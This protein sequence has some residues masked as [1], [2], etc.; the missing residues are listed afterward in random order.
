MCRN[1]KPLFNFS[2]EAT[3]EEVYQA[4]LQYVRKLSG[5]SNPSQLNEVAFYKA[6]DNVAKSTREL[7]L[8]LSTTSPKRDRDIETAKR[9]AKN[10]KRFATE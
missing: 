1:I 5:F 3:D 7:I 10:A 8:S 6:V 2:P 4:A 9:K